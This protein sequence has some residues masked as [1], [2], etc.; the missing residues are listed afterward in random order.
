[1]KHRLVS[2][3]LAVALAALAVGSP[4]LSTVQ[5]G[6]NKRILFSDARSEEV[7]NN[8]HQLTT[9]EDSLKQM[10]EQLYKSM[11]TFPS[12]SS[13]DAVSPPPEQAPVTVVPSKRAKEQLERR[14]NMF[15]LTPEDLVHTPTIE[16][17]LNVP[18]YGPDGQEKKSKTPMEKFLDREESKRGIGSKSNRSKKDEKMSDRSD[19]LG[20]RDESKSEDDSALPSGLEASEQSLR[21]LLDTDTTDNPFAPPAAKRGTFADIFGQS[22]FTPTEKQVQ[23]HKKYMDEYSTIFQTSQPSP[24]SSDV[25]SP[26][27]SDTLRLLPNSLGLPAG[28]PAG[29]DFSGLVNPLLAP[30]SPQG[31]SFQLL[32]QS[33]L[34]PKLDLPRAAATPTFVAPRRPY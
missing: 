33:P 8:L 26:A 21:K 28:T 18:E 9:R 24:A 13:L 27:A 6:S 14:K 30:S 7:T 23:D 16:E 4:W 19:R 5:A 2:L 3:R 10:K 17:M 29:N 25:L 11:R 31:P 1:M 32:G 12:E 20:G 22:A 15:L 34:T